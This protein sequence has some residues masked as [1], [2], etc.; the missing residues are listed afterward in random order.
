MRRA[1]HGTLVLG[2]ILAPLTRAGVCAGE[3]GAEPFGEWSTPL[4]DADCATYVEWVDVDPIRYHVTEHTDEVFVATLRNDGDL[5]RVISAEHQPVVESESQVHFGK[6]EL[7]KD[8]KR[9]VGERNM[10]LVGLHHARVGINGWQYS[11]RFSSQTRM[12]STAEV[13]ARHVLTTKVF[14][15]WRT[16]AVS[17]SGRLRYRVWGR[18]AFSPS[19]AWHSGTKH[20]TWSTSR[21]TRRYHVFHTVTSSKPLPPEVRR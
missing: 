18:S 9:P 17:G 10:V 8:V 5:A 1:T 15:K 3:Y 4:A 21:A 20:E 12:P 14:G 7:A 6:G 11:S 2:L 16:G 19:Y 13:P